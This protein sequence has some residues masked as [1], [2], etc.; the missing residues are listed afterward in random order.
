MQIWEK[1]VEH[2]L[3]VLT[4]PALAPF[5]VGPVRFDAGAD[6]FDSTW[7]E[8]KG[9]TLVALNVLHIFV[10]R[11]SSGHCR[12]MPWTNPAAARRRCRR[13]RPRR[14][15]LCTGWPLAFLSFQEDAQDDDID[16]GGRLPR[17]TA[18]LADRHAPAMPIGAEAPIFMASHLP[19]T[20][21]D[22]SQVRARSGARDA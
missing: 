18:G 19:P 4:V 22:G 1:V 6:D 11:H 12:G 3:T 20:W 5:D 14:P 2:N 15:A 16:F 21:P 13:R 17:D 10:L 9:A 7:A 8:V